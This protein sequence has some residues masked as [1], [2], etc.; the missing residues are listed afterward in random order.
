[1]STG[2]LSDFHHSCI[3]KWTAVPTCIYCLLSGKSRDV[4]RR[5]FSL[6][7]EKADELHLDLSPSVVLSDFELA[8]IQAAEL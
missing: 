6:L 4:Y 2:L 3:H 1:M 5:T 8:I 7:K